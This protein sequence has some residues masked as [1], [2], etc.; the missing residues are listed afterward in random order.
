MLGIYPEKI[1]ARVVSDYS[2]KIQKI[3]IRLNNSISYY[4]DYVTIADIKR[5]CREELQPIMDKIS[6]QNETCAI[7]QDKYKPKEKVGTLSCN[8][9]HIFHKD[10]IYQWLNVDR[11]KSCPMCRQQNVIVAKIEN[12]PNRKIL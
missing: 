10:C 5:V 6:Y 3:K 2:A 7:C 8:G 9:G 1:P 12:V 4:K 11:K